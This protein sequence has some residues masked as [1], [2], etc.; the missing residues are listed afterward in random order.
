MC[1]PWLSLNV[2]Y[3]S[4]DAVTE[5]GNMEEGAIGG[6]CASQRQPTYTYEKIYVYN[7][8]SPDSTYTT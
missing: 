7:I 1:P 2:T 5:S 6:A 3:Q 8:E 4:L